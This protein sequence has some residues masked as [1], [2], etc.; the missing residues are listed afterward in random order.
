MHPPLEADNSLANLIDLTL[1]V[2]HFL[3]LFKGGNSGSSPG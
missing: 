2:S 3:T 1:G